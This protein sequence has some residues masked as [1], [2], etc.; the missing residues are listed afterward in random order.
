MPFREFRRVLLP[1]NMNHTFPHAA[2][3]IRPQR[4]ALRVWPTSLAPTLR[5][6]IISWMCGDPESVRH[7]LNA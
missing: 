7:V 2:A 5:Q 6:P 1:I 3:E 4:A